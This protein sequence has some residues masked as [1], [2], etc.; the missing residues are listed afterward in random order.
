M[1]SRDEDRKN[2]EKQGK[3]GKNT[4]NPGKTGKNTENPRKSRKLVG[5]FA[6]VLA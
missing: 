1:I 3:T 6:A 4:E 5:F 2:P